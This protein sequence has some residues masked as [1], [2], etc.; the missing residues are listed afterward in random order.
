LTYTLTK[1]EQTGTDFNVE[2]TQTKRLDR[3]QG[4][5]AAYDL[6]G[7]SPMARL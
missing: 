5:F 3:A 4:S 6:I 1:G 7:K 2:R